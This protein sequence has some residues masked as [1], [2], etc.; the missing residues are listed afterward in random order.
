[1]AIQR[2]IR[3]YCE[4]HRMMAAY[5]DNSSGLESLVSTALDKQRMEIRLMVEKALDE[6]WEISGM[7]DRICPLKEDP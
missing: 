3:D 6:N 1:M 2:Y 5:Y 4:K 7:L